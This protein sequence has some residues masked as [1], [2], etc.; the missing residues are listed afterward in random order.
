MQYK[1]KDY[2]GESHQDVFDS[3][4]LSND[5]NLIVAPTESGKT[6]SVKTFAKNHPDK[7]VALLCPMQPLVD[8][9]KVSGVA[10]GYG[11]DF[12]YFHTGENFIITTWDSIQYKNFNYDILVIDEAHL[13]AGHAGF[14]KIIPLILQSKCRLKLITATPDIIDQL[15]DFKRVDFLKP[16]DRR[17]VNIYS[18]T[19]VK[20]QKDEET[21]KEI[22][23]ASKIPV[24]IQLKTIYERW[25]WERI[26]S[27]NTGRK[28][29]SKTIFIRVNDKT[30]LR[31]FYKELT[32]NEELKAVMYYSERLREMH[33]MSMEETERLKK[34][35]FRGI[36]FVLCTSI[37]DAGLSFTV[38]RNVEAHCIAQFN[39]PNPIDMVQL[40]ARVR[41]SEYNMTL[42]I[43][44]DFGLLENV[45]PNLSGNAHNL[46]KTMGEK[47][48]EYAQFNYEYYLGY[49]E[50]YGIR[51]NIYKAQGQ[52]TEY[53]QSNRY[54]TD[55]ELIVKINDGSK[56]NDKESRVDK[57]KKL[58][59]MAQ[60]IKL[61]PEAYIDDNRKKVDLKRVEALY[62]VYKDIKS[63]FTNDT[64]IAWYDFSVLLTTEVNKKVKIPLKNY[65]LLTPNKQKEFKQFLKCI[66]TGRIDNRGK[67]N[68]VTLKRI[69]FKKGTDE[70]YTIIYLMNLKH[71]A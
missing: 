9:L 21:N 39:M 48:E 17:E 56:I 6:S 27:D 28:A 43:Y 8:N 67:Y 68:T 52:S 57:F 62:N 41:K 3:I 37:Y 22:R 58:I 54:I 25:I 2:I 34:G 1:I 20:N 65:R 45:E 49:L 38:D 60:E 10:S 70:Y 42:N 18:M 69:E 4:L 71:T 59:S 12:I 50:S 35:D 19:Q 15:P 36:D 53:Y 32:K 11:S 13:L 33:G 16:L 66:T 63:S 55:Y 30:V 7:R 46:V 61:S 23:I 26:D 29:E 44:G 24:P 64:K 31:D 47:Y 5:N 51:A 40:I 14:R